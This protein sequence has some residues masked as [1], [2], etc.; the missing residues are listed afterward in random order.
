[1]V[2]ASAG[3]TDYDTLISL[4]VFKRV[5]FLRVKEKISGRRGN[6]V[7]NQGGITAAV[8]PFLRDSRVFWFIADL[9]GVG[10]V[11]IGA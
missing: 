7:C 3:G 2:K 4:R 1:M 9:C 10:Y 11:I 8:V 5:R 6:T